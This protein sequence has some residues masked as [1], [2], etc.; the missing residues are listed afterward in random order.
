MPQLVVVIG[1]TLDPRAMSSAS[2]R[3]AALT[4]LATEPDV[5][6]SCWIRSPSLE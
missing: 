1:G 3:A 4:H 5:R 6:A 2:R